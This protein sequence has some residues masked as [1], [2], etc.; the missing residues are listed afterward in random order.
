M[1]VLIA[2]IGSAGDVH[3]YIAVARALRARGHAVVMLANPHFGPR[4]EDAGLVFEPV[5]TAEEYDRLVTNPALVHPRA[6]P[7]F[8]MRELIGATA[9]PLFNGVVRLAG[10]FG[11]DVVLRHHIAF[12]ARWACEKLGLPTAAGVLCPIFWFSRTDPAVFKRGQFENAPAWMRRL[13]LRLGRLL[14]RHLG[15]RIFNPFR[16]ELGLAPAREIFI[17]ECR[18]GVVNLGLWSPRFRPPLEDDPK[19]GRIC[20][21]AAFDRAGQAEHEPGEVREFMARRDAAGRAPVVFSMGSSVV[22]HARELYVHAAR[23]CAAGGHIGALLVGRA[24]YAPADLPPCVRA[25]TYAPYSTIFPLASAVVHH[26]GVGTTA[27]ALGAGVPAVVVPFANDEFDNAARARRLGA[28]LTLHPTRRG[29][30]RLGDTLR[31][32][33]D[34]AP[35]RARARQLAQSMSAENGAEAAAIELE[36][37]VIA[38]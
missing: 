1:R 8:V 19:N 10:S 18:D 29:L 21:F 3:P 28:A 31:R 35:M 7:G 2:T 5:G 22:H 33:L 32:V 4:I 16:A 12:G 38:P 34:D 20:G 27:A 14:V 25:F 17:T 24:E 13:R 6:G 36:R 30:A 23:A 15:D 9:R 26:G 37:A 11:P